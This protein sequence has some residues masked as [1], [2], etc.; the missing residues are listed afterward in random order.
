MCFLTNIVVESA[1]KRFL[2]E[3][4]GETDVEK[5]DLDEIADPIHTAASREV[6]EWMDRMKKQKM[7]KK[8]IRKEFGQGKK[9]KKLAYNPFR[10][11][12][13]LP[14]N[15]YSILGSGIGRCCTCLIYLGPGKS[16]C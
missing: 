4:Q 7:R 3:T 16:L 10:S 6:R 13:I 11:N 15:K 14:Q 1:P 2:V 12:N 8:G 5:L 9:N